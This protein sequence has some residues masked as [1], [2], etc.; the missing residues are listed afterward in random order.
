MTPG[1]RLLVLPLATVLVALA[2][3]PSFGADEADEASRL[4]TLYAQ[5]WEEYLELNPLAATFQGDP[6]YNDRL[7]NFLSEAYRQKTHDFH[8]SWLEQIESIGSDGPRWPG[9]DQLPD[10]HA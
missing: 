2:G 4:D 8:A 1:I 7:P 6:R 9:P 5:Y 10:L 3:A